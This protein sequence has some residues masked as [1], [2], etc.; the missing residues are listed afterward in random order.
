MQGHQVLAQRYASSPCIPIVDWESR[1]LDYEPNA[2]ARGSCQSTAVSGL[3]WALVAGEPSSRT[4]FQSTAIGERLS[5][6]PAVGLEGPGVQT[7]R[8]NLS[9]LLSFVFP[10]C[11][12]IRPFSSL[13][14]SLH[15]NVLA[16][17]YESEQLKM[18]GSMPMA[19]DTKV[20]T[21]ETVPGGL[22]AEERALLGD[23]P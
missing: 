2:C 11:S 21:K 19:A 16:A 3:S 7:T 12:H 18:A 1:V 8:G 9:P 14:C 22:G 13:G 5:A 20:P 23:D 17:Y 4:C 10:A 6:V 15:S